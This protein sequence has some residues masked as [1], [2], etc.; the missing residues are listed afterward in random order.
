MG[1][2]GNYVECMTHA[3]GDVVSLSLTMLE[4][5]DVVRV[6]SV[7]TQWHMLAFRA[8]S[9]VDRVSNEVDGALRIRDSEHFAREISLL[10]L[11][12]I[13]DAEE[14]TNEAALLSPMQGA[15]QSH[16]ISWPQATIVDSEQILSS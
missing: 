10:S 13:S 5:R 1:V 16:V 2:S 8:A 9:T 4:G 12:D 3:W 15:S 6:A 14:Y 7:C 11:S